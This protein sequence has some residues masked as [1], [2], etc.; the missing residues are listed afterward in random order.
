M[1]PPDL[2]PYFAGLNR[3]F[4]PEEGFGRWKPGTAFRAQLINGETGE[5]THTEWIDRALIPEKTIDPIDWE[6][7]RSDYIDGTSSRY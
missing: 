5:V 6:T 1:F 7:L 3:R 4:C 2:P